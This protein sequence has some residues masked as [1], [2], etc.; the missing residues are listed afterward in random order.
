M[1]MK[2]LIATICILPIVLNGQDL[3]SDCALT[4]IDYSNNTE[5]CEK[6]LYEYYTSKLKQNIIKGNLSDFHNSENVLQYAPIPDSVEEDF[7]VWDIHT[8]TGYY[9]DDFDDLCRG[10]FYW[11][12]LTIDSSSIFDYSSVVLITN[13]IEEFEIGNT[14]HLKVTPYFCKNLN[15]CIENGK[16]SVVGPSHTLFD[17]VYKR[18]M[19]PAVSLG[20]NFFFIN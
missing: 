8:I 11:V 17:L 9:L 13:N 15:S 20:I 3:C 19:I 1:K 12:S 14:Y 16:K 2:F 4:I 10:T 7:R 6:C 18:W 5:C